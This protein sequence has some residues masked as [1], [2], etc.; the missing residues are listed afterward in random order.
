M[1]STPAQINHSPERVYSDRG[2][3]FIQQKLHLHRAWIQLSLCILPA[4]SLNLSHPFPLLQQGQSEL[5]EFRRQLEEREYRSAEAGL[6]AYLNEHPG[7]A[8]AW[9]MLGS[10]H[11]G[12]WNYAA[13]AEA[14]RT[15]LDLG[16]EN[17]PLLR[18][19]V[20]SR[21]MAASKVSLVFTAGKL[22]KDLERALELDPYHVESRGILAAFYYMVPGIVGGDKEKAGRLIQELI[23][24]SP[25]DGYYLRGVR[26]REEKQPDSVILED[27][28]LALEHDPN[29]TM[30]LRDLGQFWFG[31]DADEI[32]CDYYRQAAESAPDDPRTQTS[33]GRALRRLRRYEESAEQFRLALQID[34]YWFDARL[35]LAEYYERT[36][37]KEAAIREYSLLA[38][39]NPTWE[40]KEIR[41][42][43]RQLLK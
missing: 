40:Q 9:E 23:E 18:G 14:Y 35:N 38:R 28:N 26:A 36:G 10:A 43:L 32:A 5:S 25:A 15:A 4:L 1:D 34:P 24:L 21:A 8:E 13:A 41:K 11:H 17:A 39:N 2:S 33:Y 12:R 19:W 42:R 16:R 27:W 22:K 30:T 31:H 6:K 7:D 29:H 3:F 20:E 37:E